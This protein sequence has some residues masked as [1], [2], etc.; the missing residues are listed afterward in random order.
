MPS[1]YSLAYYGKRKAPVVR[2]S[3]I[4]D[5]EAATLDAIKRIKR[6]G[7]HARDLRWVVGSYTE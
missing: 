1:T 7:E 4:M 6:G 3:C 5:S 2:S